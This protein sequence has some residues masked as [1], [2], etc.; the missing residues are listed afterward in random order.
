MTDSIW[1]QWYRNDVFWAGFWSWAIAQT[2]KV[3]IGV[4]R[5]KRFNFRWFVG[6]GGMPSSHAALVSG[7]TLAAGLVEGF[8]SGL[9]AV[10]FGFAVITMFDAQGVRRQS[11]CQAE[12]LNKILDD[13]YAHRGLRE[14][15]LKELFGHTP[16]EVFAGAF[17]GIATALWVCLL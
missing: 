11:G 5:E 16:V 14:E 17:L 9:F 13:L 7:F 8:D 6:S 2:L 1:A 12:A 15:P 10:A 4:F 3:V